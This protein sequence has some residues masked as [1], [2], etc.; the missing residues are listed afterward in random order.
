MENCVVA[1]NGGAAVHCIEQRA[2]LTLTCNDFYNNA[3]GDWTGCVADLLGSD[4]NFWADPLF[5]DQLNPLE[6]F[7][8]AA[9]SPCAPENNPDCGLIGALPVGCVTTDAAEREPRDRGSARLSIY[10]NPFNP[11]T[12]VAFELRGASSVEIG[13]FDLGGALVKR[14]AV[15]DFAA[16]KHALVWDGR[17]RRGRSVPAGSYVVRIATKAGVEEEKVL[18]LR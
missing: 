3:D 11:R 8:L 18:V 9:N 15:E 10:P 13:V 1:F 14:L 16:G 6:P 12:T 5:C 4:G 2:E 7:A 17:D